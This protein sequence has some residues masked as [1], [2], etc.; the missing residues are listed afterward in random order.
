MSKLTRTTRVGLVA[1]AVAMMLA[2]TTIGGLAVA[3]AQAA[4]AAP[5]KI[6]I[7]YF[8][9]ITHAPA[10][11]ARQKALFE[12]Y[13]GKTKIEYS[14][15]SVGTAEVEALKGGALDVAFI[16]PNPSISG[17]TTTQGTL[18]RV[19]SGAVS[20]G[21]KF[22][23]KPELIATAGKPTAAEIK[24]L[25]GHTFATPGLGGTQDV[26]LRN[27]LRQNSLAIGYGSGAVSISPTD[28]ASTLTLLQKGAVDGA[29][30]PEPWA[31]RLI[32]EGKGK[33]FL[34][35]ATLWPGGKFVTTDIVASQKFLSAYP[36]AIK[37][38]LQANNES[39]AFLNNKSNTTEAKNTVQAEL[40]ARTG[41]TLADA[42]I[43]KAWPSLSFTADPLATTLKANFIA[44]VNAKVLGGS[45]T[46]NDIKGIFDL[47]IL[48][49]L[50]K[51][52]KQ[53]PVTAAGF[54]KE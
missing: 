31:T 47:R 7:G 39:I 20:G 21:A 35:E 41:K 4:S 30:V 25:K 1:G 9:N 2:A 34:D 17:Y 11:I 44:G 18:L 45:L 54:G 52:S 16:G 23:V 33:L 29:W 14:I 10:L 42:T 48:N 8:A 3:P 13:L 5:D 12:K 37:A 19:I 49:G 53:K 43:D 51:A 26:A 28:N 36:S 15:F 40:K 46:A 24:S 22:I 32:D 27:F 38:F 6:R 50:L